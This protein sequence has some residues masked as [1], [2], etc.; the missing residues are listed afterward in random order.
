MYEFPRF[1]TWS[2]TY[3]LIQIKRLKQYI[4]PYGYIAPYAS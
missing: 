3:K 1:I 2:T 4:Q